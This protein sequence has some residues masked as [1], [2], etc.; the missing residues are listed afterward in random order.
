MSLTFFLLTIV[1]FSLTIFLIKISIFFFGQLEHY[2]YYFFIIFLL[3]NALVNNILVLYQV[4]FK[5]IIIYSSFSNLPFFLLPIYLANIQS[6]AVFFN[7][8]V[9]YYFL[10]YA[11]F[12]FMLF[13]QNYTF[14]SKF[15]LLKKISSFVGLI[16]TDFLLILIFST[17]I[18]S[19][20]AIPPFSGF[21]AKYFFIILLADSNSILI[22]FFLLFIN[23]ILIFYYLRIIKLI[24]S[25]SYSFKFIII[26]HLLPVSFFIIIFFF[27]FYFFF[28]FDFLYKLF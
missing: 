3:I 21:F 19:L 9:I 13:L 27:N 18:F 2:I 14:K 20:S 25:F 15:L 10:L 23:L 4:K 22:S 16:N 28:Y 8:F 11:I 12:L 6:I 1:K 17:I 26:K 24:F 7:F 5:K